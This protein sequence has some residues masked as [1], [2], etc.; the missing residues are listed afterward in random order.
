MTSPDA[1]VVMVP[2]ERY[3]GMLKAIDSL[4]ELTPND[5]F[6]LV[7][8]DGALPEPVRAGVEAES[9]KRGF[10]FIHKPY[11]LTPTE[12][13][14]IG[15]QEADTEF[16]VFSDND[17]LFTPNW[18]EPLVDSARELDAWLIG[19]TILDG[20]P[21]RG[22]IHA[23]GGDSGIEG[24]GDEKRYHFV[25][26][27]MRQYVKDVGEQLQRGPTTMLEFHVMMAR[28]DTF[29]KIGPLDEKVSCWADH[30]DITHTV[31][32]HGGNVIYEPAS[33]ISY[34]DPGTNIDVLEQGD[35]PMFLLRWSDEWNTP[36]IERA[37]EKWDLSGK[38]PWMNHAKHWCRVRRRK[39]L[40]KCGPMGKLTGFML[41]KVN[42]GIGESLEKSV[43]QK[44]TGPLHKLR[45]QHVGA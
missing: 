7:V 18:F 22:W 43:C 40:T 19:P 4:Y 25:P 15:I 14:N 13:R 38:D 17:V 12:A 35:L 26:N 45:Q 16:I 23:A 33:T 21:E 3:S 28:R 20:D 39:A 8:G 10:K 29:D 6:R 9:K 5:R 42:E 11:P 34:H 44:Y 37:A 41:Y 1:T 36:S 32:Q 24:E 2:R 31:L 27:F 30:D